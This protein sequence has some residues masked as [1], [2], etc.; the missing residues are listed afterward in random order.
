MEHFSQ[1]VEELFYDYNLLQNAQIEKSIRQDNIFTG[2]STSK[3][4]LVEFQ[5]ILLKF[6]STEFLQFNKTNS[7]TKRL[8]T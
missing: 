7:G 2:T 1:N 8:D 6:G 4:F 3:V 5:H